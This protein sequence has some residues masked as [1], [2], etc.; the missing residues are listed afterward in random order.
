MDK[1]GSSSSIE[2]SS[3]FSI[4]SNLA[5]AKYSWGILFANGGLNNIAKLILRSR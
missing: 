3:N 1:L 5:V 4:V 2:V